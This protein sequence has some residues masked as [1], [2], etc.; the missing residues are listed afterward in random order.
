MKRTYSKYHN[1]RTRVGTHVLDSKAEARYYE[2]LLLREKAGEISNLQLQVRYDLECNGVRIGFYK[3]DFEWD[4]KDGHHVQDVK[5]SRRTV[6]PLYK[7][8]KKMVKAQYG[9]DIEEVYG[10]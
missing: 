4:D 9:V 10:A 6:T 2:T 8:K 5:G 3:S 7:W 1:V